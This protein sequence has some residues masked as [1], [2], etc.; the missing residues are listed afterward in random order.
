MCEIFKSAIV[1][2]L[3]NANLYPGDDKC[4]W[5]I[6]ELPIYGRSLVANRDIQLNEEIFHDKPLFVGP[7]VNNYNKV[8]N[9]FK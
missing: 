5:N 8:I 1:N 7:R 3:K 9:F 6:V 2:H 4:P